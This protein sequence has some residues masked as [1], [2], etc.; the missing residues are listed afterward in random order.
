MIL[1][2]SLTVDSSLFRRLLDLWENSGDPRNPFAFVLVSPLF[3]Q[4]ATLRL[5]RGELKEKRGSTVYFDSGGYY[6]QQGKLTHTELYCALRDYYRN[7]T[8]QWAD[9]YVLP[10]HVPTSQDLPEVV[11]YKVRD[12]ITAA[13]M[14]HAEMPSSI[15][16]RTIPVIQGHTLEQINKCLNEY[17]S[18]G[19]KYL[20]FGS[21][22]TSGST[23]SINVA[24]R[25]SAESL[26]H[27]ITQLR[28]QGVRL[29]TFGISTP[30]A[31]YAF[32]RMGIYS[33]D[34]LGWVRSGGYG[35]VFLPF[36]RAYNV[37]HRST[38]NGA[39]TE[40]EFAHLKDLTGHYCAFCASFPTLRDNRLYRS[41]HNLLCV[42]DTVNGHR[43][44]N[45]AEIANLI[46]EKSGRYYR[47]F[48]ELY[49]GG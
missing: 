18:M 5:V 45:E 16:G 44:L 10:D 41:L 31:I 47:I 17:Q 7:P 38:R 9:W 3:A 49:Q 13:K 42:L 19:A 20:G 36:T 25:R 4:P 30:P 23:N 48:K 40:E 27:I 46:A 21:F 24:D 22:G 12:T 6:V 15:Q 39:L 26:I 2:T 28:D 1:V 37:S 35:K 32:E 29:H 34:S 8:N 43:R 33:F 11:E 14:F